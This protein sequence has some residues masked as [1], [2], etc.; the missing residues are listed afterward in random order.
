M[1]IMLEYRYFNEYLDMD[2]MGVMLLTPVAMTVAM[3]AMTVT[4]NYAPN[5]TPQI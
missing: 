4:N 5:Y 2:H 1:V 3:I